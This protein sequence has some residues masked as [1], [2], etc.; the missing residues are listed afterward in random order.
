M[1]SSPAA[2]SG[3][4]MRDTSHSCAGRQKEWNAAGSFHRQRHSGYP[5]RH[6]LL[7]AAAGSNRGG[8]AGGYS[9]QVQQPGCAAA[10]GVAGKDD[11]DCGGAGGTA[12]AGGAP[13]QA[14]KG[15]YC[16]ICILNLAM[17]VQFESRPPQWCGRLQLSTA[18]TE[19]QSDFLYFFPA[20][21]GG[22]LLLLLLLLFV[23]LL[24]HQHR[25]RCS[26]AA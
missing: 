21:G 24:L 12:G 3:C 2:P 8:R 6:G 9:Y 25:H 4:V 13:G 16:A 23:F 15:L 26:E 10:E 14:V 11:A 5:H 17:N 7:P 18:I 22:S 19:G 20:S 1:D